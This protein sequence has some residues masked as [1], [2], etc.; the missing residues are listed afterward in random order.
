MTMNAT[1]AAAA[2]ARARIVPV[3][4]QWEIPSG[5]VRRG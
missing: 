2:P 5:P 1:M 4:A 3:S